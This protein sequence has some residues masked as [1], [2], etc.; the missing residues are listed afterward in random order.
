MLDFVSTEDLL[1]I[2]VFALVSGLSINALRH[3]DELGLLKPAFVD[4]ATGYRRYEPGQVREA[5]MICALRRVDMPIDTVRQAV[6]AP[7]FE[8]LRSLLHRHRDRLT[9]RVQDLTRLI[10]VVD[11]YLEHGVA[12]PELKT[13]R[14]VQVSINVSDLEASVAFYQA[15]FEATY[16]EELSS[17]IL[18]V[19]PSDEFFM[20]TVAHAANEHGQ[21][22]GPD[23]RSRFGLLVDDVDAVHRRALEAGATEIEPP[24]DRPWK[25]RSSCLTDPSGNRIDLYQA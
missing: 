20:L 8:A 25:P 10:E 13:P 2:G 4:P 12:M 18:G 1:S 24:V 7:D 6:E 16:Y 5:R 17:F 9:R 15:V 11:H 19:W 23:G 3:Y 21:H 14:I 22:D